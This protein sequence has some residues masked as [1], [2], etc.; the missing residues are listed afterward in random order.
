MVHFHLFKETCFGVKNCNFEYE[1]FVTSFVDFL[2]SNQYYKT[3]FFFA[4][5]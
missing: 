2:P 3:F 1:F 5:E 4:D